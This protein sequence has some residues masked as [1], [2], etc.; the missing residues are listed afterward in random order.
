MKIKFLQKHLNL[1]KLN[2]RKI[3]KQGNNLYI[4]K[5]L[6]NSKNGILITDNIMANTIVY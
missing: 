4:D 3:S 2:L 1:D 6:E 5:Y